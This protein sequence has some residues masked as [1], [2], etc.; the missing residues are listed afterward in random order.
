[1]IIPDHANNISNQLV[2]LTRNNCF[3]RRWVNLGLKASLIER[4]DV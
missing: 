1:M 3:T 2:T 4:E